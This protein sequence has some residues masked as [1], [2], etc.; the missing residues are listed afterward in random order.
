MSA[1]NAI[2]LRVL[3]C[4]CLLMAG[5]GGGDE[6]SNVGGGGSGAG[7]G[8]GGSGGGGGGSGGGPAPAPIVVN[9]PISFETRNQ[10]LFGPGAPIR[11]TTLPRISLMSRTD[12]PATRGRIYENVP[13]DVPVSVLQSAWDQ[14]LAVCRTPRT[15]STVP[16]CA[17]L[18]VTP[19][20]SACETGSVR[21]PQ[22]VTLNCCGSFG[23]PDALATYPGC[24]LLG[25][26]TNASVALPES[27]RNINLGAGIG[28]RPTQPA[29]A[30]FDV[31]LVTTYES[32]VDVGLEATIT[33]DAGSLEVSYATTALLTASSNR[34]PAGETF[35]LTARHAPVNDPARTYMTSRYPGIDFS[36][37][38]FLD[39]DAK[40][41]VEYAHMGADGRQK[42][43]T[44]TILSY[45]TAARPDADADGRLV[46]ELVGLQA[47]LSGAEVR[48]FAEQ[49]ASFPVDFPAGVVW[50]FPVSFG[51]D[52][53][54]PYTCPIAG[55]PKLGTYLCG[56]PPPL[57]TDVA[58]LSV[59]TPALDTPADIGF[60]GGVAD[61]ASMFPLLPRRNELGA[62]GSL[63]S[64]TPSG[65]RELLSTPFLG[66]ID[67]LDDILLD[68]GQL[69]TDFARIDLDLDGLLSLFSGGVNPLG[70]N[71]IFGGTTVNPVTST[72][73]SLAN[74]E[75]NLL[76]VDFANWFHVEQQLTFEPNLKVVL[77]F[78]RPVQ[79]RQGDGAFTT[80]SQFML[81]VDAGIDSTLEIIQPTGGVT[82]TPVY[83]LQDNRFTND[84]NML[85]TPARQ[86]SILQVK[87]GGLLREALVGAVTGAENDLNFAVAQSTISAPP[88]NMGAIGAAPYGLEG[89]Q[90]VAGTPL[91]IGE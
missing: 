43:A 91:T 18:T 5:C 87:V 68:D 86:D 31:G 66:G 85:W 10:G 32:R 40:L 82:I 54:H 41:D 65:F 51:W 7:G 70:G 6:A 61:F 72:V 84:T 37:R 49:P 60:N 81:R 8:S 74:M 69:S 80:T 36:F 23:V 88:V 2:T 1:P 13:Q 67:N 38:Y 48:I 50:E 75:F 9:D 45:S 71:F 3:A 73:Q 30:P 90:S 63:T 22:T 44:E 17:D 11:T 28:P 42:R 15:V 78:S 25:S 33:T 27:R 4:V 19:T 24:G 47:G 34:V 14:A 64:S 76:D 12:G 35:T 46:G 29:P 56:P 53:T 89:F 57:S 26:R 52:I 79:V 62:D 55:V 58:E 83:T 16:Y 20:Q 77:G 59:G 39:A 21:L